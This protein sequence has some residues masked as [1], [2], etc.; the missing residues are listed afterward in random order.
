MVKRVVVDYAA[1]LTG[2][3]L[4]EA[5]DSTKAFLSTQHGNKFYPFV[6]EVI[7]L[8][9]PTHDVYFVTGEPQFVADAVTKMYDTQGYVS[10]I[11]ATESDIF[12]GA[13]DSAL[14]SSS[15]KADAIREI[16]TSHDLGMSFAFGDSEGDH[17]MLGSVAFPI[18]VNPTEEFDAA[19]PQGWERRKGKNRINEIPFFVAGRLFPTQR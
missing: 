15:H 10:T 19:A 18:M 7:S 11:F 17:G 3:T 6:G 8:V 12:T 13:I 14:S 4:Q 1:G 9:R 16:L 5:A 2:R